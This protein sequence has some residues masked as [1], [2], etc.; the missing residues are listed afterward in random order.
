MPC[1][2]GRERTHRS[3]VCAPGV[4]PHQRW[5][6]ACRPCRVGA[7]STCHHPAAA[8]PLPAYLPTCFC[9]LWV[10]WGAGPSWMHTGTDEGL[11]TTYVPPRSCV[12]LACVRWPQVHLPS[13]FPPALMHELA[14]DMAQRH[15]REQGQDTH[16]G[17]DGDDMERLLEWSEGSPALFATMLEAWLARSSMPENALVDVGMFVSWFMQTKM[18]EEVGVKQAEEDVCT[19]VDQSTVARHAFDTQVQCRSCFRTYV[20]LLRW[21]RPTRTPQHLHQ[22]QPMALPFAPS[23]PPA[24]AF[25]A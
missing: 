12:P 5:L 15:M 25:R 24:G 21:F 1:L 11:C 22:S 20:G 17:V 8:T 3:N 13:A 16:T 2:Q 19:C 7:S 23:P 4:W 14:N 6:L 10:P 18:L 9:A